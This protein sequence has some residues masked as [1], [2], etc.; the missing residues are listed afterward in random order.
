MSIL[1]PTARVVWDPSGRNVT[2]DNYFTD[3]APAET[4]LKNGLTMVGTVRGNKRFLPNSFKSGRQLALHDSEFAYNKNATVLKYQSKRRK[5]VIL[6]SMHDTGIV[7][8]T[9]RRARLTLWT[10]WPTPI[11]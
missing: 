4:L 1:L 2:C 3:M 6:S 7:G 5:S 8:T 10:R 9:R 11:L